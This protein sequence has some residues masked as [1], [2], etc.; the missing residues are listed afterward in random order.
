MPLITA[1]AFKDIAQHFFNYLFNEIFVFYHS[2]HQTSR[3][4][5]QLTGTLSTFQ[6]S[7]IE[8]ITQAL[9][10]A[11]LSILFLDDLLNLP[12]DLHVCPRRCRCVL[13]IA[14][15]LHTAE[16]RDPVR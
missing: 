4:F 11:L 15:L 3:Y 5:S 13:K 8:C 10:V 16:P 7:K 14:L 9:Q 2:K 12:E 1:R 6:A